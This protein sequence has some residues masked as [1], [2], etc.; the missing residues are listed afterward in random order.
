M[1]DDDRCPSAQAGSTPH[2]RRGVVLKEQDSADPRG[3]GAWCQYSGTDMLF[4]QIPAYLNSSAM[5][6]R[7]RNCAQ[8][9]K[10]R[11][12]P[13]QPL[14]VGRLRGT[15]QVPLDGAVAARDY[16]A[17]AWRMP[18]RQ[19]DSLL[20]C[21]RSST[22][23][24]HAAVN[25]RWSCAA[26]NCREAAGSRCASSHAS[27][28]T[29]AS[30]LRSAGGN[31]INPCE[32]SGGAPRTMSW[33]SWL[34]MRSANGVLHSDKRARQVGGALRHDAQRHAVFA[35]FLGNPRQG[36]L[37]RLETEFPVARRIT[38]RLLADDRDRDRLLAPHREVEGQAA[39]QR[40]DDVQ[41]LGWD[42]RDVEDVIGAVDRNAEGCDRI[43]GH[44]VAQSRLVPT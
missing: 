35:P 11:I 28:T 29:I 6:R 38:V 9:P 8:W 13:A 1:D 10:S 24:H 16:A 37:G 5:A 44:L 15:T 36:A 23:A 41:H 40:D 14:L 12:D 39:D 27:P 20:D 30:P 4:E 42:R 19:L 31:F 3:G 33:S 32:A 21:G 43:S 26:G 7:P 25:G 34:V 18:R 2:L 22:S 17:A